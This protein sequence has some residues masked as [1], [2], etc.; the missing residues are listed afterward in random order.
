MVIPTYNR[1]VFVR[2]FC[3]RCEIQLIERCISY[4]NE[5]VLIP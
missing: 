1:R 2:D 5:K 4:A 3:V